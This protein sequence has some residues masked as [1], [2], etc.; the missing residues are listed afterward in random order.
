[1]VRVPKP[2]RILRN[3]L[4]NGASSKPD[5]SDDEEVTVAMMTITM[6]VIVLNFTV[7]DILNIF[8][9]FVRC[10][11]GVSEA[12]DDADWFFVLFLSDSVILIAPTFLDSVVEELDTEHGMENGIGA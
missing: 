8:E 1:M 6:M 9:R 12:V 3:R 7:E 10:N 11:L 5:V 4:P 2:R